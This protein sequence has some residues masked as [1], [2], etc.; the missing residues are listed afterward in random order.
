MTLDQPTKLPGDRIKKA[1]VLLAELL[2]NNP[3]KTRL[4]LLH[5]IE[6]QFDL[7]PRECEFLNTHF[8][9]KKE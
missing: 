4:E 8:D 2:E 9:K 7:T 6:I 1:I 3:E 5:Q